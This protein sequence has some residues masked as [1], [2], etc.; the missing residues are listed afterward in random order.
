M[1]VNDE[2]KILVL[3]DNNKLGEEDGHGLEN[4][5]EDEQQDILT[6]SETCVEIIVWRLE[7]L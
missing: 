3:F 1:K 5:E 6:E 7:R 4:I 2:N